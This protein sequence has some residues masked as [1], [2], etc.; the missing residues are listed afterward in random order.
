MDHE[1]RVNQATL[2]SFANP[3]FTMQYVCWG[4]SVSSF[5]ASHC[6]MTLFSPTPDTKVLNVKEWYKN[7]EDMLETR[8]FNQRTDVTTE[9]FAPGHVL[10]LKGTHAPWESWLIWNAICWPPRLRWCDPEGRLI[11]S[12]V[13]CLCATQNAPK[14]LSCS[15]R[16]AVKPWCANE[17]HIIWA[18]NG[19]E[20]PSALVKLTK[21]MHWARNCPLG[22]SL[23]LGCLLRLAD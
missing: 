21:W 16:A 4:Y 11:L 18:H 1:Q 14:P 19:E 20:C 17:E 5:C 9:Y 13:C 12:Q 8:E 15:S 23:S 7:R 3:G 10:G 22:G 2:L 6:D